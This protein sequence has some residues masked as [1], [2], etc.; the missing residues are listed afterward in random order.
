MY[1]VVGIW[2]VGSILLATAAGCSAPSDS[3]QATNADADAGQLTD[4][5]DASRPD[6]ALDAGGQ[7]DGSTAASIKRSLVDHGAWAVVS[8]AEDPFSDREAD[9]S[10]EP[11]GHMLELLAGEEVLS[12]ET[13][14]C[15]Y[16]TF[17]QPS[18][19]NIRAGDALTARIW[20]FALLADEPAEAHVSVRIGNQALL[21][22]RIPI[23]SNGSLLLV[24]VEATQDMSAG[25]PIYF[26][27]H[28]HGE[29]S[30]AMVEVS[31]TRD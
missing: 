2:L 1:K 27:L 8:E 6:V 4:I 21:D 28:N 3:S 18:L 31:H 29:N 7:V 20:H 12:V 23:P 5:R 19:S 14:L 24:T 13:G 26:H 15:S 17:L 16:V 25:T 30:W 10:C 9:G 22:Q 11:A